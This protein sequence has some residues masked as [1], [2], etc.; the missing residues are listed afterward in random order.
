MIQ[1]VVVVKTLQK[2]G[3]KSTSNLS[4][5]RSFKSFRGGKG[6][7]MNQLIRDNSKIL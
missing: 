1:A 5:L 3:W 2:I 6:Y 4:N 7:L